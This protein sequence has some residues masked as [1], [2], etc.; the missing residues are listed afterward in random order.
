M[1]TVTLAQLRRDVQDQADVAGATVRTAPTLINRLINQS[2]QRFRERLSV[3]GQTHFLTVAT[4]TMI[5]GATSGQPFS[6]L[7]VGAI[8]SGVVRVFGVD[9]KIANTY[10]SLEYVPFN[11]R[12]SFGG[13]AA[14]GEPCAWSNF[15]TTKLAIL[16]PPN[17]QYPFVI[18]YLPVFN[19]LQADAQT[20]DGVSGW[21]DFVT[22]DVCCRL[23]VRDQYPAAYQM[24]ISYK[25]E[26]WA[27]ILRAA[28]K[29]T[30]A[31]GAVVGRDSMGAK[32][33]NPNAYN[34]RT[35]P[36]P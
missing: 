12:A 21:E 15:Q 10:K 2:I 20:F 28:T 9:V 6:T 23:I 26:V 16:P 11:Q 19:D 32:L 35:L 5:A 7:D 24:A 31:G 29:V 22:W 33:R 4:G 36:Q 3:E 1:R 18:W 14:T 13:P 27:D 8:A 30:S 34:R 25:A 17:G